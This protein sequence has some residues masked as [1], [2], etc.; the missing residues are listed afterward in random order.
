[1]TTRQRCDV[2]EYF[3]FNNRFTSSDCLEEIRQVID[4]IAVARRRNVHFLARFQFCLARGG[5]G[6]LAFPS[7]WAGLDVSAELSLA[8]TSAN[9]ARDFCTRALPAWY[10]L[11][12]SAA[13][14][15]KS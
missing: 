12:I 1:V 2:A 5:L 11:L 10:S 7:G 14:S 15:R 3:V 9:M 4:E 13:S 6:M 8:R